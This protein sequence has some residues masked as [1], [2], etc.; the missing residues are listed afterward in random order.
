MSVDV[1]EARAALDILR[2]SPLGGDCPH[3]AEALEHDDLRCLF[4]CTLCDVSA[5][6]EAVAWVVAVPDAEHVSFILDGYPP[7][8]GSRA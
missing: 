7:A 6:D 8:P 5:T 3:P 1:R 2:A 4:R